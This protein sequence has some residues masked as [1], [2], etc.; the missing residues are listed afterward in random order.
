MKRLRDDLDRLRVI[1][2]TVR[3]REAIKREQVDAVQNVLLHFFFPHEAY[4][5]LAFEKIIAYVPPKSAY[6]SKLP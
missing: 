3:R 4:L 5:R 1:A 6:L 2:G